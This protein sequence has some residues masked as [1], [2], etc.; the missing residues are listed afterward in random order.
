VE[1]LGSTIASIDY[2]EDDPDA[3]EAAW[4]RSCGADWST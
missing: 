3:V 2:V 1:G 4:P